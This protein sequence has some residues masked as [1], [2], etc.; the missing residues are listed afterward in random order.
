MD[1][2]DIC[3]LRHHTALTF[4]CR[5]SFNK[6]DVRLSVII[7]SNYA[8]SAV[9]KNLDAAELV[10]SV[11]DALG[12]QLGRQQIDAATVAALRVHLDWIQYKTSFREPAIIRRLLDRFGNELPIV[13]LAVDLRQIDPARAGEQLA[14]AVR[15]LAAAGPDD[16]R[17]YLDDFK[18]WRDSL[19]WPFN[20]L[21]W[22]KLDMWE[23]HA[24]RGYEAALPSGGSDSTNPEA[25][26]DSVGEF[27]TLLKDLESRDQLPTEIYAME[28]GVGSGARA[29]KWLDK[30]KAVDDDCGSGYY[31]KLR[32]LLGD[33]SP[34]TLDTALVALGPHARICS[35]ISLDATNPLKTFAFLRFKVLFVHL[36]NVYDNL[37]FDELAQRDGQLYMVEVR[38][39]ISAEAAAQIA[40]EFNVSG[41]SLIDMMT[42][43]IDYGPEAIGGEDRGMTF[44]KTLW[45]AIQ[46]EERL[47]H[48]DIGDENNLPQGVIRQ[49]LEDLLAESPQDIRFHLSRGAAES[50]VNTAP[51]LHPRGFLQVLDVFV[52]TMQGYM[53]GFRGPGKLDGSFVV[54][55][56]GAFLR[57][58]GARAGF[59]VHFSPFR[60]R[61][62]SRTQI[63]YTTPRE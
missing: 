56:N 60:Y 53:Q 58:V 63:L 54:W 26:T 45:S 6:Y 32:F 9:P 55:V 34:A 59:D 62:G 21:F 30:F 29:R 49:A 43:L 12:E 57:A 17:V 31:S 46:M 22:R 40:S 11:T 51:L 15:Q 39:F 8:P 24:H 14:P 4:L 37:S 61:K 38:P 5:A 16:G 41:D 25:V 44:W 7:Q 10:R 28:L 47:R 18:P 19:L 27:W 36:T 33:Y 2:P 50:F 48:L 42:R 1:A 35:A 52:P 23:K 13:E 20:R 3:E